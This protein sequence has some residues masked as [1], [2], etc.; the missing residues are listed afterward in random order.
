MNLPCNEGNSYR[1]YP[2]AFPSH[3]ILLCRVL[4]LFGKER[5]VDADDNGYAEH[6]AKDDVV[7]NIKKGVIVVVHNQTLR[8]A[9]KQTKTS[10]EKYASIILIH[11]SKSKP[12]NYGFGSDSRPIQI[13]VTYFADLAGL[14]FSYLA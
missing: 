11:H 3:K 5:K 7:E 13:F 2:H 12:I 6:R 8:A 9:C 4:L 1:D 14:K 10:I